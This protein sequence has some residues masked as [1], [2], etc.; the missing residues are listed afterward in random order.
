MSGDKALRKSPQ[1]HLA[2]MVSLCAVLAGCE[3]T[4]QQASGSSGTER[5]ISGKPRLAESGTAVAA[6]ELPDTPP[7]TLYPVTVAYEPAVDPVLAAE[8]VDP[9]LVPGSVPVPRPSPLTALAMTTPENGAAD[10][11]AQA[12]NLP[13]VPATEAQRLAESSIPAS[14]LAAKGARAGTPVAVA[15]AA[16]IP[17]SVMLAEQASP[18]TAAPGSRPAGALGYAAPAGRN[19]ALA[20]IDGNAS[21][22]T[23]ASRMQS[24]ET[25]RERINDLIA[26][27]AVEY[28]V[29]EKLVH[30]VVHRESRYDPAAYNRRGY[31][32]LMQIA[33]PTAKSMGYQG[34]ANGLLDAETNLKY[35]IKYLRGA[36]LVADTDHDNAV[37][38][39]ARGY[40]YDAKRKG[41][42][43]VMK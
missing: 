4:G 36:Y 24:G 13:G 10:P 37:R 31:F 11:A 40:Y 7:E 30:R 21:A 28:G 15:S 16:G 6:I 38:L 35:A 27:Y 34:P 22:S 33:Y 8:A 17:A 18:Q 19:G 12:D 25:Q 32:G 20:A 2:V 3:T 14:P 39:Y 41:M 23:A 5:R 43:H 42:L 29:P 26:R 1:L 9:S